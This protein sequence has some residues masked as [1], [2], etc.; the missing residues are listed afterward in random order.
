VVAS[1]RTLVF[2]LGLVLGGFSLLTCSSSEERACERVEELFRAE[3]AKGATPAVGFAGEARDGCV[4]KLKDLKSGAR[5]CLSRCY[6]LARDV[7]AIFD[8]DRTCG[9][10]P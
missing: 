6:P 3:H 8:C 2:V 7:G 1:W 4:G 5:E 9:V 10:V